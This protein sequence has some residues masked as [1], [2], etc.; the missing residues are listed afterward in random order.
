MKF[1][2]LLVKKY[3]II[4]GNLGIRQNRSIIKMEIKQIF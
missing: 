3:V 1:Y 2:N 4:I